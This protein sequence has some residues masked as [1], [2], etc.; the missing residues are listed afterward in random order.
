MLVKVRITYI[1]L[2][3]IGVISVSIACLLFHVY[4]LWYKIITIYIICNSLGFKD[5][6]VMHRVNFLIIGLVTISIPLQAMKR[7]REE[8][9]AMEAY[10]DWKYDQ[11]FLDR[12]ICERN[13]ARYPYFIPAKDRDQSAEKY[14]PKR[15]F[16]D[17]LLW[18]KKMQ[19]E[20]IPREVTDAI[21][22]YCYAILSDDP[23]IKKSQQLFNLTTFDV[24]YLK[25]EQKQGLWYVLYDVGDSKQI[26]IEGLDKDFSQRMS[27]NILSLPLSIRKKIVQK[28]GATME[29]SLHNKQ[30]CG[31]RWCLDNEEAKTSFASSLA[32]MVSCLSIPPQACV[33]DTLRGRL[34]PDF[35]LVTAMVVT[36]ILFYFG[37]KKSVLHWLY[38]TP[39]EKKYRTDLV[40]IPLLQEME[41]E[42][43]QK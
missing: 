22:Q 29:S 17:E 38:E 12:L 16:C 1:F 42:I 21:L 25:K 5:F 10:G 33:W 13:K 30:I 43:V 19:D 14:P 3:I 31:A 26:T 18:A 28:Y 20:G 9:Q 23:L 15:S 2:L 35:S 37:L 36:T 41:C 8:V 7:T 32:N 11:G 40:K 39:E 24:L 27:Q 34:A 4:Y 6:L